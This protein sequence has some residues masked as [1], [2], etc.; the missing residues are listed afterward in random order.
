MSRNFNAVQAQNNMN[1]RNEKKQLSNAKSGLEVKLKDAESDL[2]EL[3]AKL[4]T[5][6]QSISTRDADKQLLQEQREQERRAVIQLKEQIKAFQDEVTQLKKSSQLLNKANEDYKKAE[7]VKVKQLETLRAKVTALETASTQ[8][9]EK[10]E[11]SDQELS[12]VR[13]E[14]RNLQDERQDLGQAKQVAETELK[15]A[16]AA[17]QQ[18]ALAAKSVLDKLRQD[19]D[20]E[21]SKLRDEIA[22]LQSLL[23]SRQEANG[24]GATEAVSRVSTQRTELS[25]SPTDARREVSQVTR[26][27]TA[28]SASGQK[29]KT[30]HNGSSQTKSQTVADKAVTQQVASQARV[31][32]VDSQR[33]TQRST[34]TRD[35]SPDGTFDDLPDFA[36]EAL[37]SS[38]QPIQDTQSTFVPPKTFE[39]I[40][41]RVHQS[42]TPLSSPRDDTTPPASRSQQR[43]SSGPN[44][45]A[46][47]GVR[48]ESNPAVTPLSGGSR[49]G[50][51]QDANME[52]PRS[53][54]GN[55][56]TSRTPYV[57]FTD[58]IPL[59]SSSQTQSTQRSSSQ[60][61]TT[62]N[63][64]FNANKDAYSYEFQATPPQQLKPSLKRKPADAPA[65]SDKRH[66]PTQ[67]SGTSIGSQGRPTS[68]LQSQ[69][70]NTPA[71]APQRTSS[72]KKTAKSSQTGQ[73]PAVRAM[74]KVR[75]STPATSQSLSRSST[76]R[77]TTRSK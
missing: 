15:E 48:H 56:L 14:L 75:S 21:S 46:M 65:L 29:R 73:R 11:R 64:Q 8:A 34:S 13:K 24:N 51:R 71:R 58:S 10:S 68:S 54:T 59:P 20:D 76:T 66:K 40:N 43:R 1:Y 7:A 53:N 26:T 32:V 30:A 18:Q 39:Q 70:P 49:A 27:K 44:E 62:Q 12:S 45:F 42:S 38:R 33:L 6:E 55:K 28:V 50:S 72:G 77:V 5:L 67:D 23:K 9:Q 19:K 25:M 3:R 60:F 37:E 69:S 4:N 63:T 31:Q 47:P 74:S 17:Q 16:Q 35:E 22:R 52:R 41:N 61:K 57:Q 2:E 36:P